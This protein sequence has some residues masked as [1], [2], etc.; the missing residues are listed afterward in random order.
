MEVL[1]FNYKNAALRVELDP[2]LSAR[3]FINNIQRM[4]KTC[5]SPF[6]IIRLSS[7]VQ[8]DYEWHEFIEALL[9]F[10]DNEVTISLRASD[11]EIA[12]LTSKIAFGPDNFK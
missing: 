8:T 3:L 4:E 9:T 12:H 11:S 5:N 1:R 2:T 10:K 6:E 7:S